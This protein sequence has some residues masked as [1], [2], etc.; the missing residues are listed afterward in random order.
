MEFIGL[1]SANNTKQ[2]I[3]YKTI[4]TVCCIFYTYITVFSQFWTYVTIWEITGW[5]PSDPVEETRLMEYIWLVPRSFFGKKKKTKNAAET[6]WGL[7]TDPRGSRLSLCGPAPPWVF[8][9]GCSAAASGPLY[10]FSTGS[11]HIHSARGPSAES[12][13]RSHLKR[14]SIYEWSH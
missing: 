13:T 8:L 11:P 9:L 6:G 3:G 12:H 1:I 5:P 4:R 7:F 2:S 10:I 14:T